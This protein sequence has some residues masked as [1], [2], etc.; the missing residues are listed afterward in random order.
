MTVI[1]AVRTPLLLLLAFAPALAMAHAYAKG[2]LKIGHPWARPAPAGAPAAGGYLTIANGGDR[3]DRLVSASTPDA[4]RVEFH[5]MIMKGDVML[6]RPLAGGLVIPAGQ[7][8]EL[9]PGGRH[10]MFIGPRTPFTLGRHVPVTLRFERAGEVKVE[11]YVEAAPMEGA[12]H[13]GMDM[14]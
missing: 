6:M 9:K 10:V 5:E 2:G 14:H 11:F 13:R 4:A 7:T 3:P 8:V 1:K 12:D